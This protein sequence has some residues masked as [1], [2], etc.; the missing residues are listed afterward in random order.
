MLEFNFHFTALNS[1]SE[2]LQ[3][4]ISIGKGEVFSQ[5]VGTSFNKFQQFEMINASFYRS[6][7]RKRFSADEVEGGAWVQSTYSTGLQEI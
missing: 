3:L 7:E 2:V 6:V 1:S 4:H 5:L